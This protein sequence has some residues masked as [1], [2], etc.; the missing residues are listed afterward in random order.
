MTT[1]DITIPEA[2]VTVE[3]KFSV[4]ASGDNYNKIFDTYDEAMAYVADRIRNVSDDTKHA[5]TFK[6]EAYHGKWPKTDV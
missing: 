4:Y 6:I 2:T 1:K 5:V 3:T